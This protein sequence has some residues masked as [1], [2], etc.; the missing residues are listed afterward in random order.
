MSLGLSSRFRSAVD[1]ALALITLVLLLGAFY[2]MLLGPRVSAAVEQRF[3]RVGYSDLQDKQTSVNIIKDVETGQCRAYVRVKTDWSMNSRP[4]SSALTD[5]WPVPCS[6]MDTMPP[7]L[8]P[9][10]MSPIR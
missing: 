7:S 1:A 10:A 9:S 2:L 5:T 4:E 6:K 3:V 8:P